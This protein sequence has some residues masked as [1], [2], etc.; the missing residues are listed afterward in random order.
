MNQS[1]DLIIVALSKLKTRKEL[2]KGLLLVGVPIVILL[3][4]GYFYFMR[5]SAYESK[6]MMDTAL[7]GGGIGVTISHP[8]KDFFDSTA[9]VLVAVGICLSSFCCGVAKIIKAVRG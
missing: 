8:P 3:F 7:G 4:I 2:V 5:L 9:Q 6:A 1:E